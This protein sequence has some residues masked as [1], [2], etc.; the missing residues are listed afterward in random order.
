M[1]G[2]N[3]LKRMKLRELAP[4]VA[5]VSISLIFSITV[6]EV[7]LASS[8][9]FKEIARPYRERLADSNINGEPYLETGDDSPYTTR[10]SYQ[11]R[12]G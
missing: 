8:P 12:F 9:R 6:G 10:K 2:A 7:L 1:A 11:G 3:I 5:L 4:R